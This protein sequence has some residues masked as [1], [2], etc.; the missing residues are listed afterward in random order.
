MGKAVITDSEGSVLGGDSGGSVFRPD[1]GSEVELVGI[2][3]SGL[4]HT[5]YFSK[6]GFI[7]MELGNSSNWDTC[8]SGC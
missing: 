7:Y 2:V 5:F 3:T 1:T 6:I 4:G 8:V